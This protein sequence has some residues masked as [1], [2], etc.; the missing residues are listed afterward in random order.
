MDFR[1]PDVGRIMLAMARV[2]SW[3]DGQ[4]R[5]GEANEPYAVHLCHVAQLVAEA[6]GDTDMIIA[7]LCHDAIEDANVSRDTLEMLFGEG[8]A[9]LVVELT[10]DKTLPKDAR[11][12]AQIDNAPKKSPRAA[13]LKLCDKISN[14]SAVGSSPPK[15]WSS[16]RRAAY[17]E[18]AEAVVARLPEPDADTAHARAFLEREFEDVCRVALHK[19]ELL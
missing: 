6:G 16:E 10:D 15:D 9:S 1:T 11:K 4:R 5:K 8:V 3:H 13:V 17:V 7:A 18:W 12:Q 2:I 19:V 14:V